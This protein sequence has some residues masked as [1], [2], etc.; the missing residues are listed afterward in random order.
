MKELVAIGICVV[1]PIIIVWLTSRVR[2]NSQNKRT[3]VLMEAIKLNP[4][5][6]VDKL[7]E[8]LAKP[9]RTPQEINNRRLLSGL[10]CTLLSIVLFIRAALEHNLPD[11]DSAEKG[12][13]GGILL[14]IGISYLVVCFIG[15]KQIENK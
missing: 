11:N 13:L 12:M 4:N 3:Q 9:K 7:V 10:I 6:D 8:S 2:I 14:A 15:R 1:L 5:M